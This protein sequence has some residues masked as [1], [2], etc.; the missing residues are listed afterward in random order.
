MFQ[1]LL[2]SLMVLLVPEHLEERKTKN[3]HSQHLLSF[4]KLFLQTST[5]LRALWGLSNLTLDTAQR[6]E[7]TCSSPTAA[8]QRS[9][10]WPR[11][12]AQHLYLPTIQ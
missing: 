8:E 5:I 1:P 9:Q 6:G 11:H 3:N 4:T 12:V 10:L 2:H 7:V